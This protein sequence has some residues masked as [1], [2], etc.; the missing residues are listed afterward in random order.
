MAASFPVEYVPMQARSHNV[1]IGYIAWLFGIFG[2]HR[3]Y[4]GKPLTGL[5]WLLT[6]GVFLVGWIVD[7]FLVPSMDDEAARR[8]ATGPCEYS[9]TWLLL[10]FAGA[11]GLH[12]FYMGKWLTGLVYLLTGGLLFIG[13]A[14]D[15]LTL[16]DQIHDINVGGR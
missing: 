4:F 6:G 13:V 1:V 12:R 2:A 15:V 5:I 7:F 8:H 16:N 3:F 9:I 11:F 14:Y 10:A